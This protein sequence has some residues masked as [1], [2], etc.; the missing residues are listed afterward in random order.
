[1]R[2]IYDLYTEPTDTWY[3]IYPYPHDLDYSHT[4]TLSLLDS[5]GMSV[6]I[7]M[8]VVTVIMPL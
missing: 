1:M 7:H 5:E 8:G 3:Y 2:S 4:E 6:R